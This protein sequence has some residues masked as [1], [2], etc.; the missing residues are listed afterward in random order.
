M[1][2]NVV[3]LQPRNEKSLSLLA[4]SLMNQ[5]KRTESILVWRRVLKINPNSIQATYALAQALRR[6]DPQESRQL[7]ERLRALKQRDNQIDQ[8]K[9]LGNQAYVAMNNGQ[10]TEAVSPLREAIKQCGDCE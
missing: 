6:T 3:R 8:V 7:L 4:N 5:S 1:L 2:L 9:K 10:W